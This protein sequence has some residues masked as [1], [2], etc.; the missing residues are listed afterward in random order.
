MIKAN[1]TGNLGITSATRYQTIYGEGMDRFQALRAIHRE[2][3]FRFWWYLIGIVATIV[4]MCFF[5]QSWLASLEVII[6]M[7]NIDFVC[8]GKVIGIYLG[9]LDCLFYIAVCS[10]AG[11][12]GEVIKMV[13]INIPLN[14]VAII[15]WTKNI[16]SQQKSGASSQSDTIEIRKLSLKGYLIYA[17]VF[18]ASCVGGYFLLG[19]LNTSSLI[20]STIA[21]GIGIIAKILG[22]FRYKE[23]YIVYIVKDLI[24]ITLWISLWL[25]AGPGEAIGPMIMTLVS[26]TDSIYGYIFWRQLYRQTSINGKGTL[27]AKRPVKIKNIIKLRHMYKDLYW[28]KEV[29]V[30][31]NS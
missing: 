23:S 20:I 9:I 14:I 30:N 15:S 19:A 31:R 4:N 18:V 26:F 22:S 29:D 13:A 7:L 6:L 28:D 1:V 16:K 5:P 21:F 10:F 8:R 11:L 17:A 3:A 2:N 27:Y 25:A 24:Q 12:W